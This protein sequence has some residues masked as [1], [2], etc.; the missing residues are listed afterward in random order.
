LGLEK[1]K[2]EIVKSSD[3][4]NQAICPKIF[5]EVEIK[6]KPDL[7]FNGLQVRLRIYLRKMITYGLNGLEIF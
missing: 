7:K 1:S 3:D 2:R 5:L 4:V 6:L